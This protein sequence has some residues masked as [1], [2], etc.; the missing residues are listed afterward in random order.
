MNVYERK[1]KA[2]ECVFAIHPSKQIHNCIMHNYALHSKSVMDD[3]RLS[4]SCPTLHYNHTTHPLSYTTSRNP[5]SQTLSFLLFYTHILTHSFFIPL[6]F[7]LHSIMISWILVI[8]LVI[9]L[10]QGYSAVN[11]PVTC[12]GCEKDRSSCPYNWCGQEHVQYNGITTT[13][14]VCCYNS[15]YYQCTKYSGTPSTGIFANQKVIDGYSCEDPSPS[16]ISGLLATWLIIIIVLASVC[17][18]CITLLCCCYWCGVGCFRPAPPP[19]ITIVHVPMWEPPPHGT[20]SQ[21]N[22]SYQRMSTPLLVPS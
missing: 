2:R 11:D 9:G 4:L 8:S 15:T 10:V 18:P 3:D 19:S 14:P 13:Y 22:Q 20:Q 16:P 5:F 21:W 17:G 6:S 12:Y 1:K 7:I